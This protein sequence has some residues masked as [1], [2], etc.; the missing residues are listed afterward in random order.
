MWQTGYPLHVMHG[1]VLPAREAFEFSSLVHR[2]NTDTLSEIQ[3]VDD[4]RRPLLAYAALVL[5]HLVRIAKPEAG[6]VLRA[7]RARGAALRD[8]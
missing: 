3:V 4:A 2:V 1:Y 7:R 8:A 5:E 6:R